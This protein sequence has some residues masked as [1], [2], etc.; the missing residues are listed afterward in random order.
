MTRD[1]LE[2]C[3]IRFGA[4]VSRWPE[5]F[6]LKA[7]ALLAHDGA[8]RTL[9]AETAA[10][11]LRLARAAALRTAADTA[12]AQRIVTGLS[13]AALPA[14]SGRHGVGWLP[15]WLVALDL[16]PAWPSIAALAGMAVLGFVIGSSTMVPG[17]GAGAGGP[18]GTDVSAVVFEPGPIGEGVL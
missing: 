12:P 11:D 18:S 16:Q 1:E 14:Q 15:A 10:L 3:T 17:L 6:R 13:R 9:L 8:A 7:E 5:P 4:D 2:R